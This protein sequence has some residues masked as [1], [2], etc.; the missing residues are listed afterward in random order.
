MDQLIPELQALLVGLAPAFRYEVHNMFCHM[1]AAWIVCLGRRSISRVWETT[2]QAQERN[3]AAAFRLFSQAAWN[4][5]EVCRLL[6]IQILARLIPGT[7]IWLVVDDTL[8]HKRGAKVAFGGIFLDAVLSSK[9]HKVFRF[10]NNWVL[11]GVVVELAWRPERYF[12]LSILWRVY[13]KQGTKTKKEHRT[14]SL[15]AA[16]M[17]AVVAGWFP[18]RQFLVVADSAYIGKP[19]LRQRP[20]NVQ[21][22]GPLCWTA[23]LYEAVDQPRRGRRHGKRLATPKAM[24]HDDQAWPAQ[25]QQITFKSG[26]QRWLEVKVVTGVC[27][28]TAA[29]SPAVQVVLVRDPA[30]EWRDEALVCTDVTLS[31]AEVIEGYCRRWSVE[32]AFCDAKQML[33]FHDPQ[34]WC[35][36]SVQRAAP[37]A[38]FVGTLV[39][40][41]YAFAGKDGEHA[42]RHRP[43]YKNKKWP[44]FADMLAACRLQLWQHWLEEGNTVADREDKLAWLLE[45]VA[46]SQ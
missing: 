7:R 36:E 14:K 31:A 8:C 20:A 34:V 35:E 41:W 6:L 43:W 28:Y 3:H 22:L 11:L 33:G 13:E 24:L 25:R 12:C 18:Q 37:M 23:A 45:Y 15:L 19:L 30:G 44:T 1:V 5:D 17:I 29:G 46:T 9:R 42:Y 26:C 21:A 10:G 16:E 27:W 39:V 2:G 40:V 32:V 38:W 4:W